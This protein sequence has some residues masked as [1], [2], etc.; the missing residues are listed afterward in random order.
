MTFS[1]ITNSLAIWLNNSGII[2]F[3]TG[4]WPG[5]GRWSPSINKVSEIFNEDSG[6]TGQKLSDKIFI[7]SP[8]LL[9]SIGCHSNTLVWT[10][11]MLGT[12]NYNEII[13]IQNYS[14]E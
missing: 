13:S 1:R 12:E 2:S 8:K 5:G 11:V 14:H 3:G 6:L 9:V 10:C 4:S 7:T